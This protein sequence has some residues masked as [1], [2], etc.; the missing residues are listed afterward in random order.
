MASGKSKGKGEGSHQYDDFEN[1][2]FH[3]VKD[4]HQYGG[5]YKENGD[6]HQGVVLYPVFV[7]GS[8]EGAVF[9]S[10]DEHEVDDGSSGYSSKEGDAV[11]H[12]F[13]IVE[14]EDHTGKPLYKHSE[15]EGDSDG[16]EDRR[17]T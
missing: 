13:R 14:G 6:Q 2:D 5:E 11:F 7:F 15:E 16:D 9:Q 10:F 8:H 12:L 3:P 17:H 4:L 1:I